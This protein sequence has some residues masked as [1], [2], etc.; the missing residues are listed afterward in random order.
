M[1]I[2][3][4]YAGRVYFAERSNRSRNLRW[5]VIPVAPTRGDVP[6]VAAK[7]PRSIRHQAYK[8]FESDRTRDRRERN[9][10][11]ATPDA[12]AD[13][14]LLIRGRLSAADQ[15]QH[16]TFAATLRHGSDFGDAGAGAGAGATR[17]GGGS[18]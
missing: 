12:S 2:S 5:F 8:L 6:I 15:H 3:K 11:P 16:S 9:R 1:F 4:P 10:L 13:G 17:G 18:P 7:V 14:I